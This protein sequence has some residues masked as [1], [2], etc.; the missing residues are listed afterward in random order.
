MAPGGEFADGS[1]AFW[2][3]SV[4]DGPAAPDRSESATA[5]RSSWNEAPA[6]NAPAGAA[7]LTATEIT[8]ASQEYT[9]MRDAWDR[10]RVNGDSTHPLVNSAHPAHAAM[11]AR[12]VEL[13]SLQA[14]QRGGGAT[15]F[16]PPVMSAAA[17]RPDPQSSSTT[18][19]APPAIALDAAQW[20]ARLGFETARTMDVPRV[21]EVASTL[22]AHGFD[23]PTIDQLLLFDASLNDRSEYSAEDSVELLQR[24]HGAAGAKRLVSNAQ[25]VVDRLVRHPLGAKYV[26]HWEETGALNDP[27]LVRLLGDVMYH[28]LP[29]DNARWTALHLAQTEH[30]Y[31]RREQRR[32]ESDRERA[33][34]DA[35]RARGE[36][37]W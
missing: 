13:A 4:D 24:E 18:S 23:G 8:A 17:Q 7:P 9:Q 28:N 26:A 34:A 14:G 25:F 27:V 33:Q 36:R 32:A 16:R 2:S 10:A 6:S 37:Q 11:F 19:P 15:D 35:A 12:Y 1:G 29:K 22:A 5:P 31:A 20:N 21:N 3:G 30:E